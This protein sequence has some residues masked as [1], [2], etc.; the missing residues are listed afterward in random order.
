M[1]WVWAILASFLGAVISALGMGGG[2]ILLIY[3]TVY[4]GMSQLKAQGIHLLFFL[5]V[6]AVALVLHT[7]NK[8]IRWRVALPFAALGLPGV[9]FGVELA[10][11][12]GSQLL[13]KLFGGFLLLIGLRELFAK[14]P[15]EKQ[16]P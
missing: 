7:K 9:W 4:L 11:R 14:P 5:P 8:L 13:S 1:S 2:G 6:A 10:Q 16:E 12:A 15:E 3:L